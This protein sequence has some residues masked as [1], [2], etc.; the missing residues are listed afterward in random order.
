MY[1]QL[2]DQKKKTNSAAS[3]PT[4]K[5]NCDFQLR[6][7][8]PGQRECSCIHKWSRV[9]WTLSLWIQYFKLV[10]SVHT[11]STYLLSIHHVLWKTLYCQI[12][13][14]ACQLTFFSTKTFCFWSM[15]LKKFPIQRKIWDPWLCRFQKFLPVNFALDFN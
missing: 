3:E 1:N 5:A 15:Y 13:W 7:S 10:H 14:I 12:L 8:T 11:R 9:C 6:A 4:L 2:R